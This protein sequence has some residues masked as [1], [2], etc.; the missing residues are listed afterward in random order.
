MSSDSYVC[1]LNDHW[2]AARG[3]ESTL[4]ARAPNT[5]YIVW[6]SFDGT[7]TILKDTLSNGQEQGA[8]VNSCGA[9]SSYTPYNRGRIFHS[10]DGTDLT[11]VAD[12]DVWIKTFAPL[13]A[14]L[15][16]R[17]TASGFGFR[18]LMVM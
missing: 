12:Q 8:G 13:S 18:A 9:I 6:T 5:T 14:A 16:S 1:Y 15:L 7:Q 17:E 11:F 3:A 2:V 4:V 10:S